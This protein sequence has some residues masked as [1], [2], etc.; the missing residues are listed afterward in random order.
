MTSRYNKTI[1]QPYLIL[2]ILLLG[3]GFVIQYSASSALAAA[4]FNDPGFYM[5][6]H[7]IRIITGIIIGTFFLIVNYE[8]LK[9][10]AFWIALLGII[11]LAISLIYHKVSNAHSTARWLPVGPFNA[12]PSEFAKFATIIYLSSF[13][14]RH[15]K[16]VHDFKNGFLPPAAVMFITVILVII[17][18]D[19]STGAVIAVLGITLL[20]VG[21]TKL[22]HLSYL[23]G[24]ITVTSVIAIIS[25]PYKLNRVLTLFSP[26]KDLQGASYQ[27]HQSLISL[28]NG[29]FWGR[30][31]ADS[32][33]KNLFLPDPHTDFVFSVAGEELGFIGV[34]ILL[35]LFLLIFLR[36]IQI[37]LKAPDIFGNLLGIGLSTSMFLYVIINIGVVCGIFPVTGLP[38]PYFSYGG[39]SMIYNLACTG[40]ILN[41]SKQ[42]QLDRQPFYWS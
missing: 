18:P 24:L 25:S 23:L 29:G 19:F 9:S 6:R 41:I 39:S 3:I 38:L 35:V 30:G 7:L 4:R 40:I 13:L 5:R 14:D 32:V 37:S 17:E 28:G 16:E 33:E 1:D 20:I 12:Q 11:L 8:R 42:S 21:G 26:D 36:G 31:L 15:Q 10:I 34:T 22:L 27:I 2:T